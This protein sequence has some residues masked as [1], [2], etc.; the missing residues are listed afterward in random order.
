MNEIVKIKE[1]FYSFEIHLY[2]TDG[3]Q[4]KWDEI[5]TTN[6]HLD[7]IDAA[8]FVCEVTEDDI[9]LLVL[10]PDGWLQSLV[11]EV[12]HIRQIILNRRGFYSSIFASFNNPADNRA[13]S[14]AE[15]YLESNLFESIHIEAKKLLKKK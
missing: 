9:I 1:P 13:L 6:Y 5:I 11:H 2:I 3:N 12:C 7:Y 14:E 8:G 4:E 10:Q 15:A